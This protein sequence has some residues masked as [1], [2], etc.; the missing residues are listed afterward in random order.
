MISGIAALRWRLA[1][2]DRE[3]GYL[4]LEVVILDAGGCL[5]A[6]PVV[7]G[8]TAAVDRYLELLR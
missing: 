3:H 4:S 1:G 2:Q 8:L 5:V 7:A 6:V